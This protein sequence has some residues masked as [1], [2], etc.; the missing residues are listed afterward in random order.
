M[1]SEDYV[2]AVLPDTARVDEKEGCEILAD[3]YS[4]VERIVKM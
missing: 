1:S 2:L 3:E 4:S